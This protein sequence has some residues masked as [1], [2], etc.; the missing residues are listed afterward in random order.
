MKGIRFCDFRVQPNGLLPHDSGK[1]KSH[2]KGL[3]RLV[4]HSTSLKVPLCG[5]CCKSPYPQRTYDSEV[6]GGITG[7]LA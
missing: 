5:I 1:G 7:E 3:I 6:E 4:I 2:R